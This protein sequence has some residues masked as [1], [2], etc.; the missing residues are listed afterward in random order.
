V[1]YSFFWDITQHSR[2]LFAD[3]SGQPVSPIFE[4]HAVQS[5]TTGPLEMGPIGCPEVLV[6]NCQSAVCNVTEEHGSDSH[7]DGSMES[8]RSTC[9]L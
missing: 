6:T 3:I 8:H 1:I 9:N 5:W 7:H 4:G 2:L